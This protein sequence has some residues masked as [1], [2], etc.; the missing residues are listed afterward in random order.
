MV[1]E[2]H[3]GQVMNL[4][5]L[6]PAPWEI[7]LNTEE[8][9]EFVTLAR[10]A[11]ELMMRRGWWAVP[12]NGIKEKDGWALPAFRWAVYGPGAASI[13]RRGFDDPLTALVEAD[14]WYRENIEGKP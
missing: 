7:D 12:M 2:E 14:K 4:E 9:S 13:D 1:S 10:D 5:N 8:D 3:R 11:F 6:T